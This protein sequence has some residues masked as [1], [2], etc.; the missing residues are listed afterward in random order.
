MSLHCIKNLPC[1][2]IQYNSLFNIRAL[3]ALTK[4]KI[5]K[6][7]KHNS[8]LIFSTLSS[9]TLWNQQRPWKENSCVFVRESKT[10]NRGKLQCDVKAFSS[11]TSARLWCLHHSVSSTVTDKEK[12]PCSWSKIQRVHIKKMSQFPLTFDQYLLLSNWRM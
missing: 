5:A 7:G 8:L 12:R 2:S 1:H 4:I 3:S 9:C 11:I 10:K 6:N